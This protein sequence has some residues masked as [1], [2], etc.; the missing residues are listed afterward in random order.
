V[1][2][3]RK[4]DPALSRE[5]GLYESDE[6][7]AARMAQL[8]ERDAFLAKLTRSVPLKS[9]IIAA[10]PTPQGQGEGK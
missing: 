6:A 3:H 8:D 7:Y 2:D 4:I 9:E 10:A 1:T 5:R